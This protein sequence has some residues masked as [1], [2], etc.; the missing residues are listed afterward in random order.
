MA[1]HCRSLTERHYVFALSCRSATRTLNTLIASRS[2]ILSIRSGKAEAVGG[3]ILI[4]RSGMRDNRRTR[5]EPHCPPTPGNQQYANRKPEMGLKTG[6][7][8]KMV[9]LALP[10]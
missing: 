1:S 3:R 6:K 10:Q 5:V 8:V 9:G 7:L 4:T 2:L